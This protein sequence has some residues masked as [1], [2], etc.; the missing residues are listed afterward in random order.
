VR[1]RSLSVRLIAASIAA[2]LLAVL[3]FG[4]GA[5]IIV[6]GQLHSSLD[7]SLRQRAVEVA[8]LS[9][10]APAVLT[11]PGALE[12]PLSGRQ[13]SVEVLDR[14][15]AIVARSLALGAKLLPRGPEVAAALRGNSG[16]ADAELDGEPIRVFAAPIADVSGPAAGGV[17]L[18]AASTDIEDTLHQLS[19][20]LLL[21]GAIAVVAGGLAAAYL[22]RR[23]V[24]PLRQLSSSATTIE[25][26]GDASQRLAE[27]ATPEEIGDLARALNGMLAALE[28]SRER[29][30]RFLA[31]ASHELRT[32]LTSL[33][34]NVDFLSRHGAGEEVVADLRG[35]AERLRRLV[36]DL[37]VLERET[38]AAAPEQP[39]RL[40]RT[41]AEVS[42]GKP[43]V[44]ARIE[45][46]ATVIGEPGALARS[47]E[48]LLENAAV[49]GPSGGRVEISMKV[50]DGQVEVAIS[51]EGAGFPP[52]A[53]EVAFERFWRA[54]EAAGR[55][56]SGIGLAIVK[57]TAER[58]GGGVRASGSTVTLTLPIAPAVAEA[59]PA[60]SDTGL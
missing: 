4:V 29:E 23:S 52:G 46:S 32:P 12:S 21:C 18:V 25:R 26:T 39:V 31:D 7:R 28:R 37:L 53:E 47:L 45:G 51:D 15:Q 5:R 41:V 19:L 11:A 54:K 22:T 60:R 35:D 10:S 16:F 27:P 1:G 49:H 14:H 58:H 13:L 36:D 17:V 38:A 3:I 59:G 56:G 24:R 48:N 30:R 57:A 33:I 50:V 40:E 44:A 55:S 20:L 2:V 9:V 6:S 42:A 43:N 8:R 34:G